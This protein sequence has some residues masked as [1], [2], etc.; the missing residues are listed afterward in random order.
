MFSTLRAYSAPPLSE[1][2][3]EQDTAKLLEKIQLCAA[4]YKFTPCMAQDVC[5]VGFVSPFPD[6]QEGLFFSVE[7]YLI[8]AIKT[9]TKNVP[10]SYIKEQ[11]AH[12]K[13]EYLTQNGSP[14]HKKIISEWK[15][16]LSTALLPNVIPVSKVTL[17]CFDLNK[18]TIFVDSPSA[19]AEDVLALLRKSIGSMPAVPF[20]DGHQL[21]AALQDFGKAN[22]LPESFMLGSKIKFQSLDEEKAQANFSNVLITADDVQSQ[23]EDKA[24]IQIELS[25]EGKVTFSVKHDGSFTGIRFADS[26]YADI[27]EDDAL[28]SKALIS[29]SILTETVDLIGCKTKKE[30]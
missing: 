18:G 16:E 5:K 23:F 7:R 13:E 11:L 10:S 30:S 29:F 24:C 3:Q 2:L 21:H 27:T 12:K 19:K 6:N 4:E 15:E 17:F 20:F 8:G 28:A 14:A 25:I 1:I 22:N 26:I 9:Q